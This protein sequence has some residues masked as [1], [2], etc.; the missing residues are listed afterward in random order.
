M[1]LAED[2]G[3][4]CLNEKDLTESLQILEG[5]IGK[6]QLFILVNLLKRQENLEPKSLFGFVLLMVKKWVFQGSF[7]K[8]KRNH[9]VRLA[10]FLRVCLCYQLFK[11]KWVVMYP[12]NDALF[13]RKRIE[14]LR[15]FFNE[16]YVNCWRAGGAVYLHN[17][18]K[19][20][21]AHFHRRYKFFSADAHVAF[22]DG[23]FDQWFLVTSGE[24]GMQ[25][26]KVQALYG[27]LLDPRYQA[28]FKVSDSFLGTHFPKNVES[29][30]TPFYIVSRLVLHAIVVPPKEW[31]PLF[32]NCFS[33]LLY[34]IEKDNGD[35]H[36]LPN[37][38]LLQQL[39]YCRN[40]YQIVQ[41]VRNIAVQPC[42][43]PAI[44][45]LHLVP[46][47]SQPAREFQKI[48]EIYLPKEDR[49]DFL[50][51]VGTEFLKEIF[52]SD[53]EV[54]FSLLKSSVPGNSQ[55]YFLERLGLEDYLKPKI[56]QSM[57]DLLLLLLY[58][59]EDQ[60]KY[61]LEFLGGVKYL[62]KLLSQDAENNLDTDRELKYLIS[63][64]P[65]EYVTA[66]LN[67][68][69]R[70]DYLSPGTANN[71]CISQSGYDVTIF[72]AARKAA[73][74]AGPVSVD[75]RGVDCCNGH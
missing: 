14:K 50:R 73:A 29:E 6:E 20:L 37:V 34:V 48:L 44:P 19:E 36:T 32:F 10:D 55:I 4:A 40:L 15:D 13:S 57:S 47:S 75:V 2:E 70:P 56:F 61:L 52:E 17:A 51:H 71:S 72:S 69:E 5:S 12:W 26:A 35:E 67:F 59:D 49:F 1:R 53:K 68:I 27:L 25:R 23:F 41:D 9:V 7:D 30:D 28:R 65:K 42:S 38:S 3:R 66:F 22:V 58:V 8:E 11:E 63:F 74:A 16:Y 60:K 43:V 39:Q 54:L 18:D 31:S 21:L 46:Y 64:L 45:M 33:R 62:Q 24:G